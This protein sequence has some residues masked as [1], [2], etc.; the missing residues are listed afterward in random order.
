MDVLLLTCMSLILLGSRDS[1]AK[2]LKDALGGSNSIFAPI[3]D[4]LAASVGRSLLLTA[5]SSPIRYVFDYEAEA[6]VREGTLIGLTY[7]ERP[8]PVGRAHWSLSL[9]YQH[10]AFDQFEG[11]DLDELQDAAPLIDESTGTPT[12]SFED[13]DVDIEADQIAMSATYG[14]TDRLDLSLTLPLLY[15]EVTRRDRVRSFLGASPSVIDG[16]TDA[17][18]FGVGDLRLRSKYALSTSDPVRVA[19]GMTLSLPAGNEDNLQGTGSVGIEPSLYAASSRLPVSKWL[20]LQVFLN[21]GLNLEATDVGSSEGRW[22]LGLDAS[23]AGRVAVAIEVLGRHA[24]DR[25]APESSFDFLRCVDRVQTCQS[26]PLTSRKGVRPLFGFDGERPDYYDVSIGG[27]LNVWRDRL[28]AFM[29][30][31]IPVDESRGLR[32]DPVPLAGLEAAF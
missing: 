20:A 32:T 13:V 14:L 8:E 6:Y 25:I 30:I 15:T 4:A 16:E 1:E 31:L 27:R 12:I 11:K 29:D 28:I 7:L 9:T 5:A 2:T 18:A 17:S 22:G 21:A 19:T 3:A 24:F 23:V 26:T 10:F